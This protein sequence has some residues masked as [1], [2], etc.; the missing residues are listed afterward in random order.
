VTTFEEAK[1]EYINDCI[2]AYGD[3]ISRIMVKYEV[4]R[5]EAIRILTLNQ[6]A[7]IQFKLGLLGEEVERWKIP[8]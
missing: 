8:Q 6:L 4:D 7:H 5:S 3:E 2:R 1:E